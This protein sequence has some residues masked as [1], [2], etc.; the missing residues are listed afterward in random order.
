MARLDGTSL[1]AVL[2]VTPRTHA[3]PIRRRADLFADRASWRE[4]NAA[5]QN[6]NHQIDTKRK[7]PYR[8]RECDYP[9]STML[10]G[11]TDS[12][13]TSPA[14]SIAAPANPSRGSHRGTR[15][16]WYNSGGHFGRPCSAAGGPSV[17]S[18]GDRELCSNADSN[19]GELWRT[20]A[21]A[22][23]LLTPSVNHTMNAGEGW[24]TLA[25]DRPTYP[26]SERCAC[27]RVNRICIQ[28]INPWSMAKG[29][30]RH[31]RLCAADAGG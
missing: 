7:L 6:L 4:K 16:D 14:T 20:L 19:V 18:S 28:V 3:I 29:F 31:H 8:D 30:L 17:G 22:S 15:R 27:V 21:N 12:T 24:R 1:A 11:Q 2:V 25:N 23:E 10:A 5:C 13:A 9:Y 26:V